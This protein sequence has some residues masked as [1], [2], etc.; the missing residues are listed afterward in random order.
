MLAEVQRDAHWRIC[1]R[2]RLAAHRCHD[3][4]RRGD[5]IDRN[6]GP[7]VTGTQTVKREKIG[8]LEVEYSTSS[9]TDIDDLVVLATP[10]V[11][12]IEGLLW[13]F[14]IPC[15]GALVF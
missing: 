8:Q 3:L 1:S 2:A 4:L 5:P 15:T 11:T 9:S 6:S 10:V 12:T 14:L 13:P 7:I